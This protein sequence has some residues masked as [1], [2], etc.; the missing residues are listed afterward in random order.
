MKIKP[1]TDN[2]VFFD[3]EFSSLDPY[4]GEIISLGM[5][6]FSGEKL[7]LELEFSGEYNDF[8]KEK[9]LP[10]LSGEKVSKEQAFELI[11]EFLGKSKPYLIS[12][13]NQFDIIF[14]HKLLDQYEYAPYWL[15]ID[16]STVLFTLGYDPEALRN[17]D[18]KFLAKYNIDISKY[19][20]HNALE[21][22]K[23]LRDIYLK[24]FEKQGN[25]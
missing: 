25:I 13:V 4:L 20:R 24:M 12:Y 6:K 21:D 17:N 10:N 16:F 5:V 18:E 8:V 15:P 23:M 11:K 3:A 19:K 1:F 9:V 14:L 2:L 7:Y 22:A